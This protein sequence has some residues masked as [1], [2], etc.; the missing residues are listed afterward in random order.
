MGAPSTCRWSRKDLSSAAV[1]G[2][3]FPVGSVT[4]ML[5]GGVTVVVQYST[6]GTSWGYVPSSTGCSAP[7]GYDRCVTHVRWTL[8]Q[9]LSAVAPNNSATF[10]LV[11]R[12]R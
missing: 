8:Q 9:P 7:A 6:D 12:I 10:E 1:G 11:A 4:S 5:P 2:W 3:Y